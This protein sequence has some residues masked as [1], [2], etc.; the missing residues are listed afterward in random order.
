MIFGTGSGQINMDSTF[1]KCIYKIC[2]NESIRNIFE[3]GSWN[4]QGS[5]ICIMNA[6]INK[7]NSRLYSLEA[8]TDMYNNSLNFWKNHDTNY[9]LILLNGTLHNKIADIN[10]LNQIYNNN[11]PYY[12]EHYIP[13]KKLLET[14]KI[15]NIDKIND[16]D[17]IVIDGGEYSSQEDFNIL[18]NK[19]PKFICLDDVNVYKC[20]NIR[21]SLLNDIEW[22]LYTENLE[23]RNGWS[24]FVSNRACFKNYKS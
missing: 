19:N 2:L 11:I 1:G 18:K 12:F 21:K 15:I 20:K 3:V 16:I 7:S 13:E 8:S 22:E 6:I 10:E 24:I 23:E 17:V 4:G 9:N 14:S 5:T